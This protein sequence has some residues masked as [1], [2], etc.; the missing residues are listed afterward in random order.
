MNTSARLKRLEQAL[1]AKR[2]LTEALPLR[3]RLTKEE[4]LEMIGLKLSGVDDIEACQ[5]VL[6]NRNDGGVS[7]NSPYW[8][9]LRKAWGSAV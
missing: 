2:P 8:Q 5:K 3:P 6:S 9:T 1:F 4:W 7:A